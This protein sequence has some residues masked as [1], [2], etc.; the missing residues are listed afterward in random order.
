MNAGDLNETRDKQAKQASHRNVETSEKINQIDFSD[1]K[2]TLL[3]DE[4]FNTE[5]RWKLLICTSYFYS[6]LLLM[7][8]FTSYL[9]YQV[10]ARGVTNT[11]ITV[12]RVPASVS[13]YGWMLE[14]RHFVY[15]WNRESPE[16]AIF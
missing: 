10:C 5:D 8:D 4:Q 16:K 13:E 6:V 1:L 14:K 12:L 15:M 11:T 9:T 3:A 2:W 7:I